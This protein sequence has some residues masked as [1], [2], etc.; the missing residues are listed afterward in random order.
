MNDLYQSFWSFSV[1]VMGSFLRDIPMNAI[2]S[3]ILS[4]VKNYPKIDLATDAILE[5]Y[6]VIASNDPK[7]GINKFLKKFPQTNVDL[8]KPHNLP[9][10]SCL[11]FLKS[12]GRVEE[13]RA[14]RILYYYLNNAL[15]GSFIHKILMCFDENNHQNVSFIL[16]NHIAPILTYGLHTNPPASPNQNQNQMN[17]ILFEICELN[18]EIWEHII[19]KLSQLQPIESLELLNTC[20]SQYFDES[21]LQ[22]QRRLYMKAFRLFSYSNADSLQNN[23]FFNNIKSFVQYKSIFKETDEI[24]SYFL[25]NLIS[26]QLLNTNRETVPQPTL[27]I[28][29]ETILAAENNNSPISIFL[30]STLFVFRQIDIN[31][32]T[33]ID[34]LLTFLSECKSAEN[35]LLN[36]VTQLILGP[37]SFNCFRQINLCGPS[38]PKIN[39]KLID[40]IFKNVIEM[41]KNS[42]LLPLPFANL[43]VS[44]ACSNFPVFI[45][46]KFEYLYSESFLKL[47]AITFFDF[48]YTILSF[49][50]IPNL[51]PKEY[52]L[53]IENVIKEFN[54]YVSTNSAHKVSNIACC[55]TQLCDE[56]DLLKTN[57]IFLNLPVKREFQN[58]SNWKKLLTGEL[59][60]F[61][62]DNMIGNDLN[63]N[64]FVNDN[65]PLSHLIAC[66]PLLPYNTSLINNIIP[67]IFDQSSQVSASTIRTLQYIVHKNN[68]KYE[69]IITRLLVTLNHESD[70]QLYNILNS[71]I[72]ITSSFYREVSDS[73]INLISPYLFIGICSQRFEIRDL[74]FNIFEILPR[75]NCFFKANDNILFDKFLTKFYNLVGLNVD[76]TFLSSLNYYSLKDISKYNINSLYH[77]YL[78]V[79]FDSLETFDYIVDNCREF[80]MKE[81]HNAN[82][83]NGKNPP[84]FYLINLSTFI[85]A[86]ATIKFPNNNEWNDVIILMKT[87]NHPK[88]KVS[89][90]SSISKLRVNSSFEMISE[91]NEFTQVEFPFVVKMFW[92]RYSHEE[93]DRFIFDA[94]HLLIKSIDLN[95]QANIVSSNQ[96]SP[97][98]IENQYTINCISCILWILNKLFNFYYKCSNKEEYG[99]FMDKLPV[100]LQNEFISS[101][102]E[103]FLK[104]VFYFIYNCMKSD[105]PELE[106]LAKKAFTSYCSITTLFDEPYQII[107]NDF[108]QIAESNI[109]ASTFI[110]TQSYPS[111][112]RSLISIAHKNISIFECIANQFKLIKTENDIQEAL[113]NDY[114]VYNTFQKENNQIYKDNFYATYSNIGS[115]LAIS[116]W[117]LSDVNTNCSDLAL[118]LIKNLSISLSLILKRTTQH[119]LMIQFFV[120]LNRINT[121]GDVINLSEMLANSLDVFVEPFINSAF[122]ILTD[123]YSTFFMSIIKPWFNKILLNNN[124]LQVINQSYKDIPFIKVFSTYS[125]VEKSISTFNL[126]H[127]KSS[128]PEFIDS[129]TSNIDNQNILFIFAMNLYNKNKSACSHF[130]TYLC[131]STDAILYTQKYF[132]FRYWFFKMI[133]L[134]EIDSEL[135][136][137]E[138]F[139][140]DNSDQ[141]EVSESS[142]DTRSKYMDDVNFAL[143]FASMIANEQL[144]PYLLSFCLICTPNSITKKVLRQLTDSETPSLHTVSKRINKYQ[145]KLLFKL[146]FEWASSCG[147]IEMAIKAAK[148]S[149]FFFDKADDSMV[150]T[151][152]RTLSIFINI[153]KEKNERKQETLRVVNDDNVVNWKIIYEYIGLLLHLLSACN[154]SLSDP[155]VD[156]FWIISEFISIYDK[157][158][159]NPQYIFQI[160]CNSLEQHLDKGIKLND[161]PNDYIGILPNL[162]LFIDSLNIL[163]AN[164]IDTTL[165]LLNIVARFAEKGNF[166]VILGKQN[167][168]I[169]IENIACTIILYILPY[170][171]TECSKSL[172]DSIKTK[173]LDLTNGKIDFDI[174]WDCFRANDVNL[175]QTGFIE[176]LQPYFIESL[177]SNVLKFYRFYLK[178]SKESLQ[179]S[180]YSVCSILLTINNNIIPDSLFSKIIVLAS[181]HSSP[182]ACSFLKIVYRKNIKETTIGNQSISMSFPIKQIRYPIFSVKEFTENNQIEKV[183]QNEELPPFLP[184]DSNFSVLPYTKEIQK[185]CYQIKISPF[186]DWIETVFKAENASSEVKENNINQED[187]IP[188]INV[189]PN[190][191]NILVNS[192]KINR[193]RSSSVVNFEESG[194]SLIQDDLFLVSVDSFKPDPKDIIQ[195]GDETFPNLF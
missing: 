99:P 175:E 51:Y 172:F 163:P 85:A 158:F 151:L 35:I 70:E 164:C 39:Q 95:S 171:S 73:I 31:F 186:T 48:V 12:F 182:S 190:D 79:F 129:M 13:N 83:K 133:Q 154:L 77:I 100:K 21:L 124:G 4:F 106:Q 3:D 8:S 149:L 103:Q 127:L 143:E 89:F 86:T 137:N 49:K 166:D 10:N 59:K 24:A 81:F 1:K 191:I 192:L 25:S 44:M 50:W 132:E 78:S 167:D 69:E 150:S 96:V 19:M 189:K 75:F 131:Q 16:E 55:M 88:I 117:Y 153:I 136:I 170:F 122:D 98:N 188:E 67:Y 185:L 144:V 38:N 148:V 184:I 18:I 41:A 116:F 91:S 28:S 46:K 22:V 82:L 104:N 76:K 173:I 97:V 65:V 121:F 159:S 61:F 123:C 74:A 138:F 90:I 64:Y 111:M 180:I 29:Q 17:N 193:V 93:L 108:P 30:K 177:L 15:F 176:S 140:I 52:D 68:L 42:T 109:S 7:D 2:D 183:N 152:I 112:I 53:F 178:N 9:T 62:T 181:K 161:V 118:S 156:V 187:I 194:K 72:M 101:Q 40:K 169:T 32:D 54:L 71:F 27:K 56:Y 60:E 147:N 195:V 115:I 105:I 139:L 36:A 145:G 135:D 34:D 107:F 57:R 87:I 114:D 130:L 94:L 160:V 14:I 20:L 110:L 47:N 26:S 134:N 120:S 66:I 63:V 157:T 165:Q 162:V 113:R 92:S 141:T 6:A 23:S 128:I 43:L 33:M 126:D 84:S 142:N 45:A 168:K 102:N 179:N 125:F 174:L 119:C 80:V 37:I 146:S 58:Y 11:N 155:R 5:K